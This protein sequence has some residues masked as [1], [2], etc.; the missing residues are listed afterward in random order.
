M[1][2][3]RT[4]CPQKA[5]AVSRG[6]YLFSSLQ[7]WLPHAIASDFWHLFTALDAILFRSWAGNA[8]ASFCPI[9]TIS[10][11]GR[12]ELDLVRVDETSEVTQ[13]A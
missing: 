3:V 11:A 13:S 2:A 10:Q 6:T 5:L 8:P 4:R 9:P 1:K 12:I 7:L